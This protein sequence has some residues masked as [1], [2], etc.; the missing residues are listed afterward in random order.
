MENTSAFPVELASYGNKEV[1]RILG[2]IATKGVEA[3]TLDQRVEY[4][5]YV[6]QRYGLD[7]SLG[8][9]C[10][11]KRDGRE[12]LYL[13]N[14][15]IFQIGARAGI[16]Y[17]VEG[18]DIQDGVVVVK[19]RAT[20][21]QG[22][23]VVALGAKSISKRYKDREGNYVVSSDLENA[24]MTAETKAKMRA[25]RQLVGL[26]VAEEEVL[27]FD[28]IGWD[29]DILAA[30]TVDELIQAGKEALKRYPN[31]VENIRLALRARYEHIHTSTGQVAESRKF[32]D[33][34]GWTHDQK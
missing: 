3:L 2:I 27:D 30:N 16:S 25:V 26:P 15:A 1:P 7:I 18:V 21:P 32:L 11:I 23:F 4:V 8:A 6:A 31:M 13:K 12:F 33:F 34:I 29:R 24:I 5:Q 17:Q 19:V 20:T 28:D 14:E 10:F 9:V 22:R